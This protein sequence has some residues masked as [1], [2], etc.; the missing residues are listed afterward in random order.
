MHVLNTSRRSRNRLYNNFIR[1]CYIVWYENL[2]NG[3]KIL[4]FASRKK[5]DK[6]L[7]KSSF[8]FDVVE[9]ARFPWSSSL[10]ILILQFCQQS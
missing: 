8:V 7:W 3:N 2:I 5:V 10:W 1:Y 6:F 4:Q 9:I